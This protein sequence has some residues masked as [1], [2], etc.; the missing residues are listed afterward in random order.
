MQ[1]PIDHGVLPVTEHQQILF[2]LERDVGEAPFERVRGV[3]AEPEA[4]EGLG[5]GAVVVKLDP[6]AE[7]ALGVGGA[8]AI[9]RHDLGED[10]GALVQT[11]GGKILRVARFA[12]LKTRGGGRR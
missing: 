11:E 8:A 7:V 9:L 5:F 4:A 10:H 12:V 6:V 2:R 1:F 3:V